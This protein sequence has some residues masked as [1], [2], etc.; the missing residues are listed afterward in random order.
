MIS[1]KTFDSMMNDFVGAE[2]HEG[3]RWRYEKFL[4]NLVIIIKDPDDFADAIKYMHG[5]KKYIDTIVRDRILK[6]MCKTLI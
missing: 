2:K 1:T 4:Q 5:N 6:A 3:T